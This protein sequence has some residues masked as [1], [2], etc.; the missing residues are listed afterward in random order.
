MSEHSLYAYASRPTPRRQRPSLFGNIHGNESNATRS[1]HAQN[2]QRKRRTTAVLR[3][4]VGRLE[5]CR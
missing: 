1:P 5:L 3:C 4:G 2:Q